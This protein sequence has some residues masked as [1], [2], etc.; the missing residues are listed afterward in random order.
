M[1]DLPTRISFLSDFNIDCVYTRL[2]LT[3]DM[4]VERN[5]VRHV[6]DEMCGENFFSESKSA[7]KRS[8]ID[9]TVD[10]V[11]FRLNCLNAYGEEFFEGF[12]INENALKLVV[13][14]DELLEMIDDGD[15]GKESKHVLLKHFSENDIREAI[16][17]WEASS[18]MQLAE[19]D[20]MQPSQEVLFAAH[21]NA[22]QHMRET[23]KA[24]DELSDP[25]LV[26]IRDN[27]FPLI[28]KFLRLETEMGQQL[29]SE[30]TAMSQVIT[31]SLPTAKIFQFPVR[32]PAAAP[33]P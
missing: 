33:Q 2:E 24:F 22:L 14:C 19:Q 29:L 13:I 16:T 20:D 31:M 9:A 18:A 7:N 12:S 5:A 4:V 11:S 21:L 10:K 30:V 25:E 17:I 26:D 6:F 1:T 28:E 27:E 8:A 15:F 23:G 32:Q 3:P